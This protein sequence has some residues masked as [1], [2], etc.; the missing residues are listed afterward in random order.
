MK[1]YQ[2]GFIGTGGRSVSYA[3]VYAQNHKI[4][5]IALADPSAVN[6]KAMAQKAGLCGN[7]AEYDDWK[8]M[9]KQHEFDGVV[10]SSPNNLHAEQAIACLER[11]IAV[12]LEKPLATSPDDCR[13]ILEAEQKYNGRIL[14]G[15]V[16]RSNPFYT[17]I[18]ELIFSGRIGNV[19]SVQADELPGWGVSSIMNRSQWRRYTKSSGG[20]MLEKSCHDMDILNWLIDSRPQVLNSFGGRSIFTANPN[21]PQKCLACPVCDNCQYYYKPAFSEHEDKGEEIIHEFIRDEDCCIFNI[22]KDVSDVQSLN[23]L[24][25]NGTVANF[26][27]NF[28]V[29]G[30]KAG[31]NFHAI[32]TKGRIWGCLQ[33]NELFCYENTGNKLE[34]YDTEGDGSGHGGGD[35]LHSLELLKMMEQPDYRPEQNSYAGYL[36]AV[37]CFAADISMNESKR[38][39]FRYDEAGIVQLV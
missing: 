35:R 39:N 15:F 5:I 34:K 28:N 12:A 33:E 1:K 8:E 18:H 25:A 10:I 36:S 17:K 21:L 31:R 7:F 24:Y 23:I 32:G 29:T 19:V 9:L 16:L 20:S 30:P 14:I 38:M 13:R 3:S 22:D 26:M 11:G 4:D 6:R 2:V 37:M 27:L